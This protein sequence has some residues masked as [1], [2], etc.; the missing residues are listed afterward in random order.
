MVGGRRDWGVRAS[1]ASPP[2][3]PLPCTPESGTVVCDARLAYAAGADW[4]VKWAAAAR[5]LVASL[6]AA[7]VARAEAACIA[8]TSASVLLVDGDT[9]EVLAPPLLYSD[10]ATPAAVAAAAALAPAGHP[11]VA[12]TSITAKVV[13]WWLEGR[14]TGNAV[15]VSAS[16][17]ASAALAGASAPARLRVSDDNNQLK[18]GWDPAAGA[19]EGW[20]AAHAACAALAPRVVRPGR[21]TGVAAGPGSPLPLGCRLAGGT[22]DSVAAFVAAGAAS[23]GD[24]V[25][26]LGSTL[27]LKLVSPVRVDDGPSGVYSHRLG[28][29]WLVGGASNVG[30][31]VLRALFADAELDALCARIDASTPPL[32]AY[33]PLPRPGER[34]PVCDPGKPPVL[35]P[36]PADDAE[37]VKCILAG[38]AGV[39]AAGYARLTALGAPAPTRVLTAGGGAANAAWTAMRGRLLAPASVEAAVEGEAAVGAALLALRGCGRGAR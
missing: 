39:E 25:T 16:D 2:S 21:G 23:P 34:F 17:Y 19:Y 31:A 14:V 36:R 1:E 29:W 15:V 5:G 10:A 24:A 4:G 18:A 33:Y 12:P 26:S 11:A 20:W 6:P 38:I 27:A 35:A 30:G 22:T 32:H 3:H 13:Q 7:A 8:G 9:M 37:F 28:D